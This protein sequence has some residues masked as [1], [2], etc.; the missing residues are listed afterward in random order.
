MAR[1][2]DETYKLI[3][4]QRAAIEEMVR[5]SVSKELADELDFNTLKALPTNRISGGLV[6]RQLDLLWKVR[7]RGNWLYL[8]ILLEFQSEDD[9]FMALRI[10]TYICLTYEELIRRGE[11]KPGDKLPP[12]L[13]VALYNGRP[14]WRAATDISEL[15]APVPEPLARYLPK[16]GYLLLDLQ[17][18]GEQDSPSTDLVTSLG[19]IEREPSPENL[20]QVMRSL[21][22]RFR[23]PE[24]TELR[25]A[26]YTWVAG[27]AEAWQ[28]SE[29]EVARMKSSM[30]DETMWERVKELREQARSD[31][32]RQ[33]LERGVQ[34]GLERGVQQ[35][36]ER[37]VQQGLERGVQQG[38]ER[39]RA[40]GRALV[41]RLATKKFGAE[42]AEQLSRI[43]ENMADPERIAEV[44]DAIIDCDTGTELFARVRA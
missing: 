5:D 29:E 4:S 6:Q 15:M 7:F 17:R 38:L 9:Y 26:L 41:G 2:H 25:E 12:V 22:G 37:G 19:K 31:G 8:L 24:F 32:E 44:A 20:Q 10:L 34:Q 27:A 36:L 39:G 33:G 13:P 43:L 30:E 11:L 35:G 42:T 28:I 3:F 14:R 1:K 16:F 40:E 23:G 21:T 18:I